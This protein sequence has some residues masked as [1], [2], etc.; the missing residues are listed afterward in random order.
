MATQSSK[1]TTIGA[2][3][4]SAQAREASKVEASKMDPKK[5][6]QAIIAGGI[7]LASISVIGF[8][9]LSGDGG[10]SEIAVIPPESTTISVTNSCEAE[11]KVTF[12]ID[13]APE[14]KFK[15]E[16]GQVE[17]NT[18]ILLPGQG[19][20][21]FE[22][23]DQNVKAGSAPAEMEVT[24]VVNGETATLKFTMERKRRASLAFHDAGG[25]LRIETGP[26][27]V[28]KE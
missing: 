6:L 3:S 19:Q 13:G 23:G 21:I 18:S 27:I 5:K 11:A 12:K 4:A 16:A 2:P 9:V 15:G 28:K 26:G 22:L 10:P 7:L 24:V 1:R 20:D 17:N 8:Y 14:A 25:A